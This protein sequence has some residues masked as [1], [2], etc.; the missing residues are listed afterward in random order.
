MQRPPKVY[1]QYACDRPNTKLYTVK[2]G[3]FLN[4]FHGAKVSL[5]SASHFV[6]TLTHKVLFALKML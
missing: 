6:H 3:I 4:I 5:K 2:K 1:E